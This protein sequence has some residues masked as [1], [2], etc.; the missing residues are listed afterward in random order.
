MQAAAVLAEMG[1][2]DTP[3]QKS[4]PWLQL[5]L[6]VT[7]NTVLLQEPR[8]VRVCVDPDLIHCEC[9]SGTPLQ[10]GHPAGAWDDDRGRSPGC[11]AQPA[12]SQPADGIHHHPSSICIQRA[13]QGRSGSHLCSIHTELL[14]I[15]LVTTL[16]FPPTASLSHTQNVSSDLCGLCHAC[17]GSQNERNLSC[18]GLRTVPLLRWG[19]SNRH[20]PSLPACGSFCREVRSRKNPPHPPLERV[21][22]NRS[23][24]PMLWRLCPTWAVS[25][26]IMHPSVTATR[27]STWRV[28]P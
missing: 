8:T 24:S 21:K 10:G 2:Y 23:D 1:D 9:N 14:S 6:L 7:F 27:S 26:G 20:Q 22:T 5:M 25:N 16:P 12:T 28:D 4:P 3:F 13:A 11:S 19:G 17:N 18:N 15:L